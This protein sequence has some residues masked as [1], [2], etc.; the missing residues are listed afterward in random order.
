M[1][2]AKRITI[3]IFICTLG[4]WFYGKQE[5]KKQDTVPPVITSAISELHVDA[6]AGEAGLKEGLTASDDVDGRICM[7]LSVVWGFL[8]VLAVRW[9]QPQLMLL[10]E[11]IPPQLTW[12][13]LAVM[14]IDTFFSLR[15]LLHSH[16]VELMSVPRLVSWLQEI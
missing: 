7:P 5:M 14:I 12:A 13:V 2:I 3:F 11:E 10:V 4:I 9:V 16:D 15:I 1:K 8:V 6:A